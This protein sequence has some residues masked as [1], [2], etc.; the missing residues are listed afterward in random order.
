MNVL[1]DRL[2]SPRPP[3]P[4]TGSDDARRRGDVE[5]WRRVAAAAAAAVGLAL[6][7]GHAAAQPPAPAATDGTPT[8]AAP[9]TPIAIGAAVPLGL[10]M[11]DSEVVLGPTLYGFDTAAYVAGAGGYL[12]RHAETVGTEVWTGADAVDRVAHAYGI[13][14]RLLLA[15]IELRSGWVRDP[16]PAERSYPLGGDV[17]G[18]FNGLVAAADRLNEAYAARRF[19]GR[20]TVLL[21]DGRTVRV[22]AGLNAGS[23]AVLSL[24]SSDV[25]AADWPALAAP[26]GL[27]SVWH[28]LYGHEPL[29]YNTSPVEWSEL[30]PFPLR[31]PFADG[32]VWYFVEGPASPRGRGGPRASV[33]FAPPPAAAAGCT[34]SAEWVVAAAGGTVVR[35]DA[36]GVIVDSDDDRFVGSGWSITYRHLAPEERV[37]EGATVRAGE[38][39]G[40]PSC[41]DG[42]ATVT[43]VSL[44]RRYN[45]AWV[46]A[47]MA[48]APLVLDGWAALAGAL[49]GEGMLIRADANARRAGTAK[50]DATNGVVSGLGR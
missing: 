27:W 32:A 1:P 50:V 39:I 46:P 5:S 6:A 9:G 15:L 8:A 17:P 23:F 48:A 11:P 44:A 42:P 22:D 2:R 36:L 21:A 40:H 13:G 49:D 33:A 14:P 29:Y 7:D 31:L 45:G 20:D 28:N 3:R 18:L 16:N 35:S 38:P 24:L 19:G 12:A 26:S 4:L 41:A 47:D 10:V 34:P 25:T 37:P 43:R 30:P